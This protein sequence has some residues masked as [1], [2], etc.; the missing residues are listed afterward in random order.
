M[1][2]KIVK[3]RSHMNISL[4]SDKVEKWAFRGN[5]QA[6]DCAARG[7]DVLSSEFCATWQRLGDELQQ[8]SYVRTHLHSL[9]V[10]V[11]QIAVQS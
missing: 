1:L 6:D 3:I 4:F 7:R 5:D 2:V 10:Q 9:V 11:G 8:I